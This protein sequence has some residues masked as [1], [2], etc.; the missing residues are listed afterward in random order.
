MAGNRSQQLRSALESESSKSEI[1]HG[2]D[3]GTAE[4]PF[5]AAE[6]DNPE[7]EAHLTPT[8]AYLQQ[9]D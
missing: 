1:E 3:P 7:L 8:A 9:G 2:S 4:L 5:V 6:P